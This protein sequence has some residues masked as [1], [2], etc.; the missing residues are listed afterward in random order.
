MG[1]PGSIREPSGAVKEPEKRK[2]ERTTEV[3]GIVVA[4]A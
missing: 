3:F 4:N 2:D 1:P